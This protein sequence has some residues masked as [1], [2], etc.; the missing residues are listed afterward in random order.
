MSRYEKG[1]FRKFRFYP[2]TK[3]KTPI[4][5]QFQS[6]LKGHGQEFHSL[7]PYERGDDSRKIHWK[8]YAKTGDLQVREES[9]ERNMRIWIAE[10]LS[11]SMEFGSKPNL[12]SG[13]FTFADYL[14]HEGNNSIGI[15][16]FSDKVHFFRK[17]IYGMFARPKAQND[18]TGAANISCA[19]SFLETRIRSGDVVFIVSDFFSI[20]NLES[21]MRPFAIKQ[22]LIPVII[23]DPREEMR[24]KNARISSYDMETTRY[25]KTMWNESLKDYDS[26]LYEL[27][28]RLFLDPLWIEG[29][30]H[31]EAIKA[32]SE[33]LYKRS[34]R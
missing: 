19:L 33:W 20:E 11:H 28:D 16:G 17:P 22:E 9:A 24:I 15:I 2:R 8:H 21:A 25:L 3:V 18:A 31:N 6:R 32:I 14:S 26:L 29:E 10:D 4:S 13:F 27:F 34:K 12:V 7:R 30:K 1:L 23:R 5:G